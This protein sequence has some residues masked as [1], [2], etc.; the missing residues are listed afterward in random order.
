MKINKFSIF[1]KKFILIL[2][3]FFIFFYS[4]SSEAKDNKKREKNM[5]KMTKI[6]IKVDRIFKS[7]DIDFE[8][9]V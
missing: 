5:V 1:K 7:G 4:F 6:V 9:L 2:S 3:I 8:R